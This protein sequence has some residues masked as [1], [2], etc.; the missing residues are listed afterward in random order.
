MRVAYEHTEGGGRAASK[1]TFRVY[2]KTT[3]KTL[4]PFA[5]KGMEQTK[6]QRCQKI[7]RKEL[8]D[9]GGA[10]LE[11]DLRAFGHRPICS[12]EWGKTRQENKVAEG[13]AKD[14]Y[15]D[16]SGLALCAR[17]GIGRKLERAR[18]LEK[19]WEDLRYEV[20]CASGE[21]K[22]VVGAR[23]GRKR[24]GKIGAGRDGGTKIL[25]R[26]NPRGARAEVVGGVNILSRP[27]AVYKL[28]HGCQKLD[29]MT[30]GATR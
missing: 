26:S 21:K 1:I 7:G 5:D 19:W 27:A 25:G 6:H 29:Q 30:E 23:N 11:E 9:G 10:D 8:E 2:E 4:K 20:E 15:G 12:R 3:T 17:L 22:G 13:V 16:R 14:H 28:S 24:R 18:S